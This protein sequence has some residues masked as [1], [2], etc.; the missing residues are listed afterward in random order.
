MKNKNFFGLALVLLL[1][2][3]AAGGLWAQDLRFDGYLNSG[4][5]VVADNSD[6]DAYLKAFGVDSESNGYRFRLNG[7]YSNEAKNVGVRLRLQ[8]QRRL[9]RA[10]TGYFS[11]PYAYGWIS[12]LNNNIITV[13][14]GIVDDGTW[15]TA[16]WWWNDD[17][18]EGLGLLLKVSPIKGLDFGI[19]VY[20]ISQQSGG[21]NN[22]LSIGNNAS[23]PNF[24]DI[25]IKPKDAKYTFN[26]AYTMADTFRLGVSFRTKNRAGWNPSTVDGT[27]GY[28]FD[29]YAYSGR[30]EASQ[31]IGEFRL[32]AVKGLTAVVV[33][34]FDNLNDFGNKGNITLSETFG[35]KIG[36][37]MNL[38]LN[39]VQFFYNA[40]TGGKDTN[41]SLLFNLWGSY[42]I[43]KVVPRL[44]LVYFM[45]G[46][47]KTVASDKQWERKGFVTAKG[48]K[49][50]DDDKSVFSVRPSVKI[51]ADS[52]TF[53]E[54]GD[55]I[56]F[57]FGNYVGAYRVK[58]DANKKS[59]FTNVFYID[60]KFSF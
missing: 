47:S 24:Q 33:G 49:D 35:F 56:N 46:T 4:L 7:S 1:L 17:Q 30:E 23:L 48:A 5:G 54:I 19:G 16:D 12:F 50:V 22:I 3:A 9:E 39:A 29:N 14:G 42:A 27:A 20:T 18:G 8:S 45:G 51:N 10:N 57:D 6:A 25:I 32:L 41:P 55:M 21:S 59:R 34:V 43:N 2:M 31:L 60:V 44:D 40:Q 52:R 37:D 13:T 38:G 15:T 11:I 28:T 36:D 58:D 26:G 53:L